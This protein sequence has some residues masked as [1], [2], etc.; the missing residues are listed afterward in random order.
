MY[1]IIG[2]IVTIMFILEIITVAGSFTVLYT[3][4]SNFVDTKI[5]KKI[6]ITSFVSSIIT[7]IIFLLVST[8]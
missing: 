3:G 8:L 6:C 4:I 1:S 7:L 2:S 5:S